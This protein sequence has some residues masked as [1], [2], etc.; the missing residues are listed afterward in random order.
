[1]H[2]CYLSVTLSGASHKKS[3]ENNHFRFYTTKQDQKRL[4]RLKDSGAEGKFV[5]G[6]N[7]FL[8]PC[9]FAGVS[10]GFL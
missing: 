4:K 3:R 1:M 10:S 5:S 7:Y 8:S 2:R 9:C 6:P